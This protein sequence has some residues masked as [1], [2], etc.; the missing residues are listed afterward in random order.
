M[1]VSELA[2]HLP[3]VCWLHV[4][5]TIKAEH[6]PVLECVDGCHHTF[7]WVSS[8]GF[9]LLIEGLLLLRRASELNLGVQ[10]DG[11]GATNELHP[12]AEWGES[13]REDRIIHT[14]SVKGIGD[15]A[16]IAC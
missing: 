6:R 11:E 16:S 10:F 8:L 15:T 3:E 5:T 4:P 14:E 2:T 13:T 9:P 1:G 7:L 12:L